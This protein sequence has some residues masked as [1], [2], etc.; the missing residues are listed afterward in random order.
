MKD[1]GV[2]GDGVTDDAAAIQACLSANPGKR[3]VVPRGS[4]KITVSLK[5]RAA[6]TLDFEAGATLLLATQNM[7]LRTAICRANG[8][9]RNPRFAPFASAKKRWMGP[10]AHATYPSRSIFWK[11]SS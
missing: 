5:I 1:W 7:N 4:Y 2:K 11:Q 10:R 3:I 6:L 9:C 8:S